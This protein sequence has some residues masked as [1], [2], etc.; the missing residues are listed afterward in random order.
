[1]MNAGLKKPVKS[2]QDAEE[3]K[4][5]SIRRHRTVLIFTIMTY[6]Y[7]RSRSAC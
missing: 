5:V 1:M 7:I 6:I 3:K 4:K 2:K